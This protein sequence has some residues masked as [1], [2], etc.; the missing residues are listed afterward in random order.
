MN[1]RILLIDGCEQMLVPYKKLLEKEGYEVFAALD[2]VEALRVIDQCT[3]E[4]KPIRVVL[5]DPEVSPENTFF[6]DTGI[7]SC[8]MYHDPDL[9]KEAV[10]QFGYCRFLRKPFETSE[11]AI[12]L[13]AKAERLRLAISESAQEHAPR[14]SAAVLNRKEISETVAE[15][16]REANSLLN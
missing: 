5:Y 2:A 16:L 7:P 12:L 9:R 4:G 11:I 14:F 13:R 3:Q 6:V 15:A 1:Q 8:I 10:D